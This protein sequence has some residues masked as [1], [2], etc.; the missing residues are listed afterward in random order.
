[1][2]V[3][4]VVPLTAGWLTRTLLLKSHGKEW[5]EKGSALQWIARSGLSGRAIGN[6]RQPNHLATL[7]RHAGGV[8]RHL[9]GL[10]RVVGTLAHGGPQL[11]HAGGG[12]LQCAGLL[13]GA[14]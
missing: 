3:F 6:V 10:A 14:G 12:F 11:L 7:L 5:F 1:M 13:F 9:A 2:V 4:I 8:G